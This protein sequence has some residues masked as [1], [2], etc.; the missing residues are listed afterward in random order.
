MATKKTRFYALLI[1]GFFI[2]SR[3]PLVG[4]RASEDQPAASY[5]PTEK[6]LLKVLRTLRKDFLAPL[7]KGQSSADLYARFQQYRGRVELEGE[8]FEELKFR[9]KN[10]AKEEAQT[11]EACGLLLYDVA[12]A[13]DEINRLFAATGYTENTLHQTTQIPAESD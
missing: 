12:Y 2:V 4:L 7:E 13:V 1:M 6:R 8:M 9:N 11:R 5:K 3:A 10:P